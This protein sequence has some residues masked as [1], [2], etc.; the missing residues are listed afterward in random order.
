[1]AFKPQIRKDEVGVIKDQ[2][3]REVVKAAEQVKKGVIYALGTERFSKM[4]LHPGH[5]PFT[6]VGWRT[7]QGIH[8]QNDREWLS[9]KYNKVN[10]GVNL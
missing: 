8:N 3:S 5:P 7:P 9:E 10:L 6:V 4:P 2:T 1:M